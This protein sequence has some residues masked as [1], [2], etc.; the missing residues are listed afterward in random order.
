MHFR[1]FEIQKKVLVKGKIVNLD[2]KQILF[3]RKSSNTRPPSRRRKL[4]ASAGAAKNDFQAWSAGKKLALLQ[5]RVV[6]FRNDLAASSR[7]P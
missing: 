6:I 7:P 3:A 4:P 1:N 2:V 5:K